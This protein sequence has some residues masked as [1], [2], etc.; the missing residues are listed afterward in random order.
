MR[1]DRNQPP[2]GGER[3]NR[4]VLV[5]N[6]DIPLLANVKAIAQEVQWLEHQRQWQ[7]ERMLSI[8][9]HLSFT[10]GGGMPK[11]LDEAFA[12]LSE[13]DEEHERKIK[14]YTRQLKAAE[15]ILD[16]IKSRSMR[17][18]VIMKYMTNSRTHT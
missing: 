5:R 9:H 7:R 13:L 1:N 12:R 11:G 18:F 14:E 16:Q 8:T 6:R 15:E 10:P 17:S 4:P 3:E 2:A